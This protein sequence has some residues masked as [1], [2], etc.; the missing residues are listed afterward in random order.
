MLADLEFGGVIGLPEKSIVNWV[1]VWVVVNRIAPEGSGGAD[2]S[3]MTVSLPSSCNRVGAGCSFRN[4]D[5]INTSS[6]TDRLRLCSR[7]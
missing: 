7:L 1:M 6:G 4:A 2:T 5:V 3:L